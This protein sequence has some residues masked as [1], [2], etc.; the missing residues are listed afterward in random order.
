MKLPV[1]DV[2]TTVAPA[3]K[4]R[5]LGRQIFPQED[6]Q[7]TE[8]GSKLELRSKNGTAEVDTAR[9]GLW[10][11]DTNNLWRFDPKPGLKRDLFSPER[12]EA[13]ATDHL[14]KFALMP[15][16]EKPFRLRPA[17]KSGAITAWANGDN[18]RRELIQEDNTVLYDIEVD[19]SEFGLSQKTLP[20]VGGGGRLS[21]VLGEAGKLIGTRG[22][23]R[24]SIGRPKMYEV[25]ERSK[26]DE[27]FRSM[28]NGVPVKE[29]SAELAYYSA[30]SFTGQQSLYPVYVYSGVA[31]FGGNKVPLRKVM[32]P[33]TEISSMIQPGSPERKRVKDAIPS[34]RPLPADH[35]LVPGRALPPGIGINRKLLAA[36]GIKYS[37][38]FAE[39]A[40]GKPII[41]PNISSTL[42]TQVSSLF[43]YNSAGTSW[44]GVS[45]GLNGSKNNAKG[46]VDEMN[47]AGWTVRFNWGD[48]NAFESDWRAN[49]DQWVDAVD[50]VFYT[51]HANADGWVLSNPGDT[52]LNFS[53]TAG[54]SDLWGQ[55]DLEWAVVAACG[56]L[57]DQAI[58]SGGNVLDRWRNAFDGLHMLMGYGQ[59]TYDNEEEG[60]RLAKYAK[61]GNTIMQSWFRTGQEIQPGGIWVGAYYVGN[62]S[63][64]T[65]N[66]HLWGYGSVG[67]DITSPTM[68]ACSWVPC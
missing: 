46:F 25:I 36:K 14:K 19:A 64:S 47:S 56:P 22:V 59:V 50:F 49:D 52:F 34:I 43:S 31:D 37:D 57:Q 41:N 68:R 11:S 1:F 6:F 27:T 44:I 10:A 38:L 9:G 40:V 29:F 32:I 13:V 66:D 5:E 51:G 16:I 8:K 7:I 58:G 30:P 48:A 15:Q 65:G 21:V 24:P 28:M 60:K 12:A 26:A 33:A 39:D 67:P 63:G 4:L 20:I 18:V 23:W 2:A 35:K 42:L 17:R 61:E 54:A 3:E 62:S 45:G 55:N 53:E